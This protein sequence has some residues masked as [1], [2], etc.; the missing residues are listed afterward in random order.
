MAAGKSTIGRHLARELGVP[1][2]D[3][4][5]AI[6]ERFGPIPDLFSARGEAGFREAE[7]EAVRAVLA[8]PPSIIALGGGAVTYVPTRELL[9]AGAVRVYLDIPVEALVARLKRSQT[10]R[11]LVGSDPTIERVRA[12]LEPREPI[13]LESDIVVRGPRRSKRAFALEIAARL[14]AHERTGVS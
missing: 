4:D 6:V 7:L 12:L 3:T 5:D 10:V 8:G 13:Y 2:V 9:R 14:R 11:P 1:F